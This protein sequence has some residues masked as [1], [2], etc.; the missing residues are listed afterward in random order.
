MSDKMPISSLHMADYKILWAKSKPRHPLW[1]HLLDSSAVSLALG[2]P[3]K[4]YGWGERETALLVGLHDIG[5]SYPRFQHRVPD[6]SEELASAGFRDTSHRYYRHE[7]ISADFV[8]MKLT[9]AAHDP[10][11]I[12]AIA[13]IFAAH[14][15]RWDGDKPGATGNYLEAQ[16][17]LFLIL[18]RVLG[19][20]SFPCEKPSNL[21]AFGM[22]LLG[23]VVLCDWIASNKKF[24]C[25]ER[26]KGESVPTSYFARASGV[27]REWVDELGLERKCWPGNP[28]GVVE[29]PRPVQQ[30]LLD[31]DIPP[32]LV[33]IEAPMGEGKTEAAWI[34]AEK[35]RN[36]GFQ[37]MYMALPTMATSDSLHDRYRDHYLKKLGHGE[38][39]KLVH[40]RAWL[41]G[42]KEPE[43]ALETGE[44]ENDASIAASWFRPTRRAGL[45]VPLSK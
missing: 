44:S 6:F 3:I 5:K 14:H 25:D 15:S 31:D 30:A 40:G 24:Y 27:A 41:R 37:G 21:S 9:E 4:S 19:A 42:D 28:A 26:L 20:G 23:H 8:R 45:F 10:H 16:E 29:T 22:R 43:E 34:L 36:A 12:D 13:R 38:D 35:W 32:S 39:L 17:L 1:K 11:L 2:S 33:I 7:R 18:Q